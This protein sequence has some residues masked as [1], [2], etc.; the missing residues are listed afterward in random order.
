MSLAGR[1]HLHV[2]C[3]FFWGGGEREFLLIRVGIR[4]LYFTTRPSLEKLMIANGKKY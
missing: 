1:G 3:V 2:T 4:P